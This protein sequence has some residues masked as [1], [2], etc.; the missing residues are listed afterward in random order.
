MK[1]K[2]DTLGDRKQNMTHHREMAEAFGQIIARDH[3]GLS[4][5]SF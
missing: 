3:D 2:A 4:Q 5:R 1:P